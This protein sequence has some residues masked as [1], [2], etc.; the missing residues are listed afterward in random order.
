V[1]FRQLSFQSSRNAWRFKQGDRYKLIASNK[2]HEAITWD[3]ETALSIARVARALQFQGDFCFVAPIQ[4]RNG[5]ARTSRL[6]LLD[7]FDEGQIE[8]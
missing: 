8:S 1:S 3:A 7:A 6:S 5:V 4:F 2:T